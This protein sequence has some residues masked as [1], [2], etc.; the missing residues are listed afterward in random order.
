MAD[1]EQPAVAVEPDPV[2]GVLELFPPE[3]RRVERL[4]RTRIRHGIPDGVVAESGEVCE[5]P[6]P[7]CTNELRKLR[8]KVAEVR[9]G[10]GCAPFLAHEQHRWRGREQQNC[11]SG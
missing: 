3:F 1:R 10:L 8:M 2:C 7:A 11:E 5:F 4:L 9:E 6:A